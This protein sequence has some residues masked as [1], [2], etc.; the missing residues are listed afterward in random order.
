MRPPCVHPELK[1]NDS[2]D[3]DWKWF[4]LIVRLRQW[5]QKGN[6]DYCLFRLFFGVINKMKMMPRSIGLCFYMSS[7]FF[8]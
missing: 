2:A 1:E 8:N 3:F 6:F 5:V 4:F 7:L